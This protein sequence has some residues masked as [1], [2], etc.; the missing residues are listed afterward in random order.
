MT[1]NWGRCQPTISACNHIQ[2]YPCTVGRA[3][4]AS[5]PFEVRRGDGWLDRV[6]G[7][8][9]RERNARALQSPPRSLLGPNAQQLIPGCFP[10][11]AGGALLPLSNALPSLSLFVLHTDPGPF[12]TGLTCP[13]TPLPWPHVPPCL[14]SC[15]VDSIS[16]VPQSCTSSLF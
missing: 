13:R 16:P 11:S 9:A 4:V 8:C 14:I 15:T 7:L 6:R 3:H 1:D 12:L 10:F 5:S 2:V